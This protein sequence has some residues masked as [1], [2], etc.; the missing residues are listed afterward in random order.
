M[1]FL[2]SSRKGK[3]VTPSEY[4]KSKGAHHLFAIMPSSIDDH[5]Q[6]GYPPSTALYIGACANGSLSGRFALL[7]DGMQTRAVSLNMFL[8]AVK[9]FLYVA[10][11]SVRRAA[12][13]APRV[14]SLAP[15]TA[16]GRCHRVRCLH[17]PPS[18]PRLR[19]RRAAVPPRTL[20]LPTCSPISLRL[21]RPPLPWRRRRRHLDRT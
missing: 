6:Q 4:E 19:A 11:K 20:H 2:Y 15:R 3:C 16:A 1:D 14:P 17:C 12:R 13:P 7:A 9:R 5:K 18:P 21:T 8:D 10:M